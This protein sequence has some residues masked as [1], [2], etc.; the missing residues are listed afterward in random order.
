[1]DRETG[2]GGLW[3]I[4]LA[5]ETGNRFPWELGLSLVT[6]TH[7]VCLGWLGFY[8]SACFL[9][10]GSN[11]NYHLFGLAVRLVAQLSFLEWL[12]AH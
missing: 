9:V 2:A 6:G 4:R 5:L 8:C 10:A 11:N 1:M 3:A 7:L 12:A